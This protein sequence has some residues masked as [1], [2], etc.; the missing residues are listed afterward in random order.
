MLH[1]SPREF[2]WLSLAVSGGSVGRGE[3]WPQW[4]GTK[5]DGV[6]RETGIVEKFASSTIDAQVD[7]CPSALAIAA[8]P[9]PTA[10]CM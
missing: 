10:A 9:S 3:D 6:W 8:R 7:A 2:L 1:V 4:R 5:R